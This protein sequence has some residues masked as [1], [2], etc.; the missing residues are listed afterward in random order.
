MKVVV[1]V[2]KVVLDAHL[3]T[4]ELH[5]KQAEEKAK[6]TL[7]TDDMIASLSA[8]AEYLAA[9]KFYLKAIGKGKMKVVK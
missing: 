7:N 1:I 8:T 4:T 6:R 9:Q 3:A 5:K 2:D